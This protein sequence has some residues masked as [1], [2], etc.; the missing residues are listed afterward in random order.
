M[1]VTF[2]LVRHDA[3][4]A[5]C[6]G[7]RENRLVEVQSRNL[8]T[9]D[10]DVRRSPLS[11]RFFIMATIESVSNESRVFEPPREFV[12]QANIKK[13]DFDALNASAEKDYAGF[14]SKLARE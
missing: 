13:A 6:S 2:R 1:S 7:S 4:M 10:Q 9:L 11:R 8:A 12:A 3:S 14:W 5:E